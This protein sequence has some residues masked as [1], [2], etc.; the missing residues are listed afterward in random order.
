LQSGVVGHLSRWLTAENLG[1]DALDDA[2]VDRFCR[3]RRDAGYTAFLTP[4]MLVHLLVY[5]RGL[6]AISPAA[7]P[8]LDG[9]VD[10]LLAQ[11]RVDL[12]IER[13]LLDAVVAGYLHAITSR[14]PG[15][16]SDREGMALSNSP[17]VEMTR[18][19]ASPSRVWM[20]TVRPAWAGGTL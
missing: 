4:R 11:Y 10:E 20:L 9:L 1:V 2:V 12:L 15:T 19:F 5:L 16:C 6:G 7:V 13:G 17:A 14:S 3:A 18:M 8:V